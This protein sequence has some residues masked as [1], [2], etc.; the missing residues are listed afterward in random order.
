M[1]RTNLSTRPFYNEAA[2]RVGL[3]VVAALVVAATIFNVSRVLHYSRNDTDAA[4]QASHDEAA[5]ADLRAV[6]ARERASVDAKQIATASTEAREANDLIDRRTFS[7]TELFNR[8]EATIPANV[9]ITSVRPRLDEKD[10]R[11]ELA[12]TVLSQSVDDVNQFIEN[13]EATG[14]FERL[15]PNDDRVNDAGQHETALTMKY[16][17]RLEAAAPSAGPGQ[18][19]R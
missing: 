10:H 8:F 2:V 11:I 19:T 7:W 17:P 18:D 3:L 6:A 4:L 14:A 12:V 15:V 9:R 1:I 16:L 5:A 13:L